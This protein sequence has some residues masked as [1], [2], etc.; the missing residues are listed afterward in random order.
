V[1][2]GIPSNG[3]HSYNPLE[4]AYRRIPSKNKGFARVPSKNWWN[5]YYLQLLSNLFSN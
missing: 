2:S 5:L 4:K 3:E 1:N